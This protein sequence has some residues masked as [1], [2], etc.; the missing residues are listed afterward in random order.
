M[1]CVFDVV[2]LFLWKTSVDSNRGP[3]HRKI[4]AYPQESVLAAEMYPIGDDALR[5][6]GPV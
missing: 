4:E 2:M 3:C 1:G 5:F 6:V